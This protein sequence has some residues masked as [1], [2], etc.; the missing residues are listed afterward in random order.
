M[1][2]MIWVCSAEHP[3][4]RIGV[5]LDM[6]QNSTSHQKRQGDTTEIAL[7]IEMQP[8]RTPTTVRSKSL[9]ISLRV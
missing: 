3:S 5:S 2:L 4:M 6:P 9:S 7:D 1:L 8:K